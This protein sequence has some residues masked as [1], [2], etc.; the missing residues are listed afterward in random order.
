MGRDRGRG[1]ETSSG[2]SGLWPQNSFLVRAEKTIHIR[3][4]WHFVYTKYSRV[5]I[6]E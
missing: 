5:G 1:G 6:V 2:V 4:Y 3:V